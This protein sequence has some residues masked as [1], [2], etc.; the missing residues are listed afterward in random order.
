MAAEAAG[1]CSNFGAP[2]WIPES[3]NDEPVFIERKVVTAL[4]SPQPVNKLMK[5]VGDSS[6]RALGIAWAFTP[7]RSTLSL[8]FMRMA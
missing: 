6:V 3:E 1:D 8:N 5:K 2:V 7:F 4:V